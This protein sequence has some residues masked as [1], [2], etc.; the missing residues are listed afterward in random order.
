MLSIN[1]QCRL[2]SSEF[3]TAIKQPLADH[4]FFSI[5]RGTYLRKFSINKRQELFKAVGKSIHC[6]VVEFSS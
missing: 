4:N 6:S 1:C 2:S 5:M 3:E